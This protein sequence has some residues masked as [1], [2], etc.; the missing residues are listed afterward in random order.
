LV[1][2]A[3]A[4]VVPNIVF[5]AV[6]IPWYTLR[7]LDLSW[8]EFILRAWLRPMLCAAIAA[9][10]GYFAFPLSGKLTWAAFIAEALII[11][12]VFGVLACFICFDSAQRGAVLGKLNNMIGRPAVHEA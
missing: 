7:I 11:C 2:V 5:S 10:T 12:G 6:A 8:R 1:G 4:T 9:G 3:W